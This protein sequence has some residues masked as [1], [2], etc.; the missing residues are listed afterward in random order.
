V[1][2]AAGNAGKDQPEEEGDIGFV[3]GRVHS[4]GWVAAAGLEVDLDWR[5]IGNGVADISE[6]E[7][8]IW[9]SP[10]DRFS[11][12]LRPPGY[13]DWI[14]PLEPGQYIENMQLD[15]GSFVSIYNEVY[16]H[17]NGK[18][19]IA[20]YL[21][22]LLSVHGIVGVPAGS[23]TV[24]LHGDEIRDGRFHA[25]IERDDPR[26]VGR[27]GDEE[28]WRFPSFFGPGSYVDGFTVSSLACGER[29]ISVANLDE[30]GERINPTSSQGPTG[31]GRTKPDTAAPGTDIV[32]ANGFNPEQP[33][34]KMSGTSMASPFVCGVAGLMLATEPNL[35]A[36]QIL[37]IMR[38]TA[39]PLPGDDY[40]WRDD[41]GFGAIDPMAC[42]WEAS[43]VSDREDLTP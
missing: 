34:I 10:Q 24:R 30:H 14:G 38:R 2:V 1:T 4:S 29:V 37:G 39:H 33:W 18:N 26:R 17:A 16:H 31:D 28:Y 5:V 43:V 6:N 19:Y 40:A 11:V 13:D 21:S 3:M 41:A 35:T 25:W 15:D 27:V 36:A 42:V 22:P 9:H 20:I 12:S 23:W 32:A 8:E 7:L